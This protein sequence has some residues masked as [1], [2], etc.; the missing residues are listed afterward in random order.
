MAGQREFSLTHALF[1]KAAHSSSFHST[2]AFG[3]LSTFQ[4]LDLAQAPGNNELASMHINT[5][6]I[7]VHYLGK[8]A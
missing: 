8:F 2:A 7:L 6:R 3:L 5:K 1:G 4:R